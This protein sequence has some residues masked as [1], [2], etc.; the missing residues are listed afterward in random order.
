[1][2]AWQQRWQQ[3][4][5]VARNFFERHWRGLLVWRHRLRPSE[6]TIHLFLAVAVGVLAAIINRGFRVVTDLA[7]LLF[8]NRT[9]EIASI[10]EVLPPWARFLAP[11]A[12]GLAAGAVLQYGLRMVGQQG[13]TNLLEV[14]VAG[15]GR[16]PLRS[17]LIK[18]VSSLIS[19]AT[20]APVGREGSIT[21]LSATLASK[22]GQLA[23]APPYRLRLLLACGAAAGMASAYNAPIAGAVFA[24]QIVLGNFSM[25]LFA[26]LI[27]SSV[28]AAVLSRNFFG[29][30]PWY[31][32]PGFEFTKLRQLPWFLVLGGAA[33]VVGATFLALL[34]RS[35]ALFQK[36]RLP[37]SARLGIAGAIVGLLALQFPQVWGNGYLPTARVLAESQT[38]GVGLLV[39][40]LLARF[41]ATVVTVGA[42]TVGGVFTPTLFLGAVLGSLFGRI[43]HAAGWGLELPTAAFALVGM[44]SVLAATTHS[45]LL[46]MIMVFEISLNYSLMPALMVACALGTLIGRRL[47]PS[48]VYTEPLRQKSLLPE[49]ENEKLG[50][51]I[52]RTVGDF[53]H[54]PVPPRRQNATFRDISDRFLTTTNNFLPVVDDRQRLLGVV[55]LQDMKEYLNAGLEFHGVIAYDIM[56]P[57]PPVLTPG[58][59]LQEALPIILASEMRNVPVVSDRHEQR[60]IGALSRAEAL[61]LLSEAIAPGRR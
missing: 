61:G 37:F 26:P 52:Q 42:G 18:A 44:G 11:V 3:V 35:E 39:L 57:V 15:D 54:P 58:Q 1:V 51:A 30:D 4:S 32:A 49:A 24:A 29:L 6:E 17:T 27:V 48:S 53:M 31:T 10:A 46:A 25:N 16:L 12:G 59:S 43:I 9:G 5:A 56:R 21:Q 22:A 47:H 28:V 34:R 60:L 8:L 20:G 38:Y 50:A 55:A 41:V 45:P 7:S 13:S 2:R 33:G 14:V 19:I 36:S 40:L 23:S